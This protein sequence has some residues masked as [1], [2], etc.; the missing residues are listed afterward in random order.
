VAGPDDDTLDEVSERGLLLAVGERVPSGAERSSL[1]PAEV[2]A[3]GGYPV[4]EVPHPGADRLREPYV[5]GEGYLVGL[6]EGH[7][8]V[9]FVLGGGESL[10]EDRALVFDVAWRLLGVG[11]GEDRFD[12]EAL[13]TLGSDEDA[14]SALVGERPVLADATGGT[15][16]EPA[17]VGVVDEPKA[18]SDSTNPHK[19]EDPDRAH[20]VDSG[21]SRPQLNGPAL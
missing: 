21:R 6:A 15:G 11:E 2:E 13:D 12:D 7:Q 9:E 10:D 3:L 19:T 5:L 17:T 16:G 20:G 1:R 8:F 4:G 18:G 14:R